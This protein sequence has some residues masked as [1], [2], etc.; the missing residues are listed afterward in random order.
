MVA[1]PISPFLHFSCRNEKADIRNIRPKFSKPIIAN[2]KHMSIVVLGNFFIFLFGLCIGSFLNVVIYRLEKGESFVKGRSHCPRCKKQLAW[3]DLIPVASFLW[4]RGKCRY[5][6][7]KIS[8]QYPIIEILTGLIFLL[9]FQMYAFGDLFSIFFLFYIASALI[10]IF[11]YDLKYYIVPDSI[12]FPAIAI[13]FL[14]RLVFAPLGNYFLA[15]LIA[16]GFFLCIFLLSR[17]RWMGFGDV[18]LAVLLGLLLGFPNILVGLFL[19]FFF[20]AIIGV[21]LMMYQKIGLKTEIPFA[22]FLIL[23]TLTAFFFGDQII[24]WYGSLLF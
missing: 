20:G 4:L 3:L 23:G 2:H 5:C 11:V 18:K 24:Q 12:L 13:T 14:H 19:S 22:P 17:G 10:V 9:I 16:S 8:L 7:K 21:G 1:D 6:H 15:A